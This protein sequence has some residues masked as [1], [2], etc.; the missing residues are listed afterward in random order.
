MAVDKSILDS[1]GLPEGTQLEELASIVYDTMYIKAGDA[2]PDLSQL[3]THAFKTNAM[4]NEAFP[5]TSGRLIVLK[6]LKIEHN[7]QYSDAELLKLFEIN[8]IITTTIEDKRYSDIPLQL[9]TSYNRVPNGYIGTSK[10]NTDITNVQA[11]TVVSS[12]N[13]IPVLPQDVKVPHQGKID[14]AFKNNVQTKTKT[15]AP[16]VGVKGS[17][18]KNMYPE[19]VDADYYYYIKFTFTGIMYRPVK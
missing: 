7:L 9:Y 5:L 19:A 8:S 17:D 14:I 18:I 2:V 3:F 10:L 6:G 16:G 1:F 12:A 11:S 4:R 15:G 13:G